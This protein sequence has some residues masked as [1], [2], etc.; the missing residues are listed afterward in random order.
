MQQQYSFNYQKYADISELEVS[1][2]DLLRHARE[3]IK[4]AYAPYSKFNVGCA[5]L[6]NNAQVYTGFNIENAS[7][8]VGICAERSALS[9]VITQH[10][11]A[12]I[13]TIAISYQSDSIANDKPAFPC[14]MCRQFILECE[15][16]NK[17]KVPL[18]LSGQSG[19][20]IVLD[21]IK[22]ILP[23]YF[24]ADAMQ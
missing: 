12:T 18:I 3:A 8:P 6:F 13:N 5:V 23:F 19:E 22:D 14:G 10:P 7:Y 11:N 21:T 1:Q 4:N 20:V 15:V 9:A 17:V 16:R 2:Q 24:T